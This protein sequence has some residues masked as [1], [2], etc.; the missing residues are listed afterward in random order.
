MLRAL[1]KSLMITEMLGFVIYGSIS[2]A[3][4]YFAIP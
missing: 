2:A 3:G 1:E 4:S